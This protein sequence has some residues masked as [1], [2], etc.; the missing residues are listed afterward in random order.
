M[1]KRLSSKREL[2]MLVERAQKGDNAAIERVLSCFE[3]DIRKMA[4]SGRWFI[5]GADAEDIE[6]EARIGLFN[7]IDEYDPKRSEIGFHTFA[8]KVCVKRAIITAI[9]RENRRRMDPLNHGLSLSTPIGTSD[10]DANQIL[11]EFIPDEEFNLEYDMSQQHEIKHLDDILR[12]DLTELEE[13]SYDLYKEGFTYREIADQLGHTEKTVDNALMRVRNKA[14]QVIA[15]YL[16][17]YSKDYDGGESLKC[18][19]EGWGLN[20]D[21]EDEVKFWSELI[22]ELTVEKDNA[23]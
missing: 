5:P 9:N 14:K 7:A 19:V 6:Q 1:P 3:N 10:G 15:V 4:N 17:Q 22:E 12:K 11:E 21:V 20:I 18:F 2:D 16:V 13:Q 23:N 8:M